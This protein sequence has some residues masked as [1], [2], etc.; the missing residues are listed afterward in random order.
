MRGK[1]YDELSVGDKAAFS[2]TV[3]EA[4]IHSFSAITADFNPIHTDEVY[5]AGSS[6]GKKVGGRIVQG[7]LSASLFSTLVGMY[8]PGKGSLYVSQTCHFKRPVKIGDTLRAECE[9]LE[10]REKGRLL[11]QTRCLNQHGEVVV[12]GEAVVSAA[13]KVEDVI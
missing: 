4:D 13:R 9:V 1:T 11:M 5:A 10:K 7:M 8:L 3:T 12:E 2:K 6:L